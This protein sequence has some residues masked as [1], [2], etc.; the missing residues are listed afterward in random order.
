MEAL[1]AL[2]VELP[3]VDFADVPFDEFTAWLAR[4]TRLNVVVSWKRL[5]RAGVARDA[6]I[7]LQMKN[8]LRLE[9]LQAALE[10]VST[11]DAPLGFRAVDNI[12]TIS[13]RSHL[14]SQLVTQTYDVS[15]LRSIAPS[16]DAMQLGPRTARRS[17]P[18]DGRAASHKGLDQADESVRQLV[19]LITR[20]VFPDSWRV[21]GGLGTIAYFRGKLVI[22]NTPEVHRALSGGLPKAARP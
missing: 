13:T 19:D 15:Y 2:Y 17:D 4:D 18:A 8:V 16:F 10:Q 5:E 1:K 11:P 7:T 12:I 22:R 9:V 14:D 20:M 3:T 21:H 6:T